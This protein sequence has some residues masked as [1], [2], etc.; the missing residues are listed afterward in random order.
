MPYKNKSDY[1]TWMRRNQRKVKARNRAEAVEMLGGKCNHVD[2]NETE[3]LHFDHVIRA[4]KLDHRI[5]SW[6]RARR[7]AEIAKCQLLC[8]YHHVE[9]TMMENRGEIPRWA[10]YR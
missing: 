2:C 3:N 4:D 1:N 5:W 10:H 9:K 8:E 7:L 6:S